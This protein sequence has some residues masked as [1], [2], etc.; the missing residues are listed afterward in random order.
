[1]ATLLINQLIEERLGELGRDGPAS[2]LDR[3]AALR[4]RETGWNGYDALAPDR[5]AIAFAETWLAGLYQQVTAQ[6]APWLAPH[7]TSSAEGEVVFERWNDPRKLTVYCTAEDANFVK[8][9][10]PDMVLQMEDGDATSPAARR[11]LWTWLT[12]DVAQ[13]SNLTLEVDD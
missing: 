1:S 4:E 7:V 10:G 6:G 12:S 11:Q 3:L 8:V 13:A 9:W 5:H 2:T